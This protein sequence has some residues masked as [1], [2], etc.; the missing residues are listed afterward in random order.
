MDECDLEPE[1]SAP[2]HLVDELG[3]RR[4]ELPKR[5]VHVVGLER[6]MVHAGPASL[7]EATDV[8][9]LTGRSDE[10]DPAVADHERRRND[11]LLTE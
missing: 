10:L 6:D 8:R 4:S 11:S 2:W 1:Q 7:E 5:T 3:A 9:V